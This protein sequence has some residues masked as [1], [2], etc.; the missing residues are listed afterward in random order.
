MIE[1]EWAEQAFE[2]VIPTQDKVREFDASPE[3]ARYFEIVRMTMWTNLGGATLPTIGC[4]M[5]SA[6]R[7]SS[8]R[9]MRRR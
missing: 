2:A 6:L 3:G 8:R 9:V 5:H 7:C 4:E 1:Q